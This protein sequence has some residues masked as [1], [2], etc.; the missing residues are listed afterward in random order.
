MLFV[1]VRNDKKHLLRCHEQSS[2]SI[3]KILLR[4]MAAEKRPG[5]RW[6]PGRSAGAHMNGTAA[7]LSA[8]VRSGTPCASSQALVRSDMTVGLI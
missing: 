7:P 1:Y 8:S 2:N 3:L 6:I 4:K 5:I